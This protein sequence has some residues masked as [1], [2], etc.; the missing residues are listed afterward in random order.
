MQVTIASRFRGPPHSG[1]GGYSC[2]L[3]ARALGGAVEVSLRKP[4][5]LDVPLTIVVDG[6]R[7]T[8]RDGESD[9]AIARRAELVLDVP[10]PPS[11]AEAE[12]AA[13]HYRGF[14]GHPYP[15][16][17]VC[18]PARGEGDGL[19]IFPGRVGELVAAPFTAHDRGSEFVWAALD[20]PGYFGA[21]EGAPPLLLGTM[22][23]EVIGE[24]RVDAPHIVIGWSLGRE[25]RK[26]YAG[27]ALFDVDGQMLGRSRQVWIAPKT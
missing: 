1:N 15:G 3:L 10:R 27:T 2:G 19:R 22:H 17:F 26:I 18:G 21:V 9:V 8:L 16:C 24:L 6:E 12:E 4:P 20:C 13:R 25:G 7:A 14:H 23:A 11:L 5:P